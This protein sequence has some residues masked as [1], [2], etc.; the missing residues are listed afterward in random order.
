[1]RLIIGK[2]PNL[3]AQEYKVTDLSEYKIKTSLQYQISDKYGIGRHF[4]VPNKKGIGVGLQ[5]STKKK[6]G[7]RHCTIEE[8][9]KNNLTVKDIDLTHL[10]SHLKPFYKRNEIIEYDKEKQQ[11]LL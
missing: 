5:K 2:E 10:L 11:Q 1:M 3:A 6:A 8:F 4:L 7:I 9:N